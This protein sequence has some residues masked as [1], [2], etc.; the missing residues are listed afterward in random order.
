MNPEQ[1]RLEWLHIHRTAKCKEPRCDLIYREEMELGLPEDPVER[2]VWYEVQA[3]EFKQWRNDLYRHRWSFR[4]GKCT[5]CEGQGILLKAGRVGFCVQ[6]CLNTNVSRYP[7]GHEQPCLSDVIAHARQCTSHLSS[8]TSK[9][10][11]QLGTLYGQYDHTAGMERY[12]H[13]FSSKKDGT[14]KN[15]SSPTP[16]R[17]SDSW[18][19]TLPGFSIPKNSN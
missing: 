6:W 3:Q 1:Q 15:Y 11:E 2:E 13:T 17:N 19:L 4:H 18:N 14:P 16:S 5:N 9:D 10:I 12:G 7:S 8:L